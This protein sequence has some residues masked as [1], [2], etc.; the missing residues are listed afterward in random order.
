MF[1]KAK[2]IQQNLVFLLSAAILILCA[3]FLPIS[4][5]KTSRQSSFNT[6]LRQHSAD[7]K[8]SSSSDSQ[9]SY[10]DSHKDFDVEAWLEKS[11]GSSVSDR[12]IFSRLD[13]DGAMLYAQNGE[14]TTDCCPLSPTSAL[15]TCDSNPS[16]TPCTSINESDKGDP[17]KDKD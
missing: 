10:I 2:P 6:D 7:L 14:P 8:S 15:S 9:S 17:D 5:G 13:A 12:G 3:F 16:S 1:N 11:K 4:Y